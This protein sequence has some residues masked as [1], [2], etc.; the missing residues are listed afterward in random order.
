MNTTAVGIGISR[1]GQIAINTHDVERAT[2]FYQDVFNP[3]GE[4]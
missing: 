4:G 3:S 1:I 2:S